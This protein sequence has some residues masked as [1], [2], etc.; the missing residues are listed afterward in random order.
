MRYISPPSFSVDV[1]GFKAMVSRSMLVVRPWQNSVAGFVLK[2]ISFN[3]DK[4]QFTAF[5]RTVAELEELLR[6]VTYVNARTFPTP[7]HRNIT[8]DT[9]VRYAAGSDGWVTFTCI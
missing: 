1:G 5:G 3:S 8:V 4:T 7:G 6:G 9:V 2:V